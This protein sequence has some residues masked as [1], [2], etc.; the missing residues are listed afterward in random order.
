MYTRTQTSM[1]DLRFPGMGPCMNLANPKSF[2]CR[3]FG[4][5]TVHT[6]YRGCVVATHAFWWLC[7]S[8]WSAVWRN[9]M[10][11]SRS[12]QT[13]III[14]IPRWSTVDDWRF[15]KP[16]ITPLESGIQMVFGLHL[17]MLIYVSLSCFFAEFLSPK[18]E[19]G[20]FWCRICVSVVRSISSLS[21]LGRFIWSMLYQAHSRLG[22]SGGCWIRWGP[23]LV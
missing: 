18:F 3:D 22:M 12:L 4:T 13:L 11:Q 21:S 20:E 7:H 17:N 8:Q 14:I 16:K 9:C 5:S 1:L 10:P 6:K 23:L 15:Y 2:I 19:S